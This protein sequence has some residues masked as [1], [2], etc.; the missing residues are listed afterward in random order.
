[1]PVQARYFGLHIHRALAMRAGESRSTWP[2]HSDWSWRLWDARVAWKDI[3]PRRGVFDFSRLDSLCN[4]ARSHHVRVLLTLG[5][6]PRWASARPLEQSNYDVGNQAPPADIEDWRR[7]VDTVARRYR[8]QIEAYE[9]WNEPN[10]RGFFSGTSRDLVALARVAYAVV[11]TADPHAIVVSPSATGVP[12]GSRWL[13]EYLGAGG[14][15]YA[16]VVGFHFYVTPHDPE[17]ML[18]AFDSLR[19]VLS[20]TRLRSAPV[21]NTETGWLFQ[22]H[23]FSVLPSGSPGTFGS[24]VLDDTTGAAFVARA[25]VIGRCGSLARFYWYAWD[26]RRM[27]LTEAD[28]I[29]LKAEARAYETTR[30][31]LLGARVTSC[32]RTVN[33]VWVVRISRGR[34]GRGVIVWS[35][36]R[37][38]QIPLEYATAILSKWPLLGSVTQVQKSALA[39]RATAMPTLLNYR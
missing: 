35:Q 6:T 23:D 31:W 16:D 37:V 3:E 34:D 20:A 36:A 5:L 26:N 30:K 38:A 12:G 33:G 7:Y 32:E 25:L 39:M 8:G 29:H 19:A 9:V 2:P 1:M 18:P 21:W 14:D 22:N 24:R 17:D 13:K 27:G 11:K 10:L 28:G 4:L 15:R